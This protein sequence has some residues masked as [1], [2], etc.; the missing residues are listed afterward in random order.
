MAD[1]SSREDLIA[2][3]RVEA[4]NAGLPDS[5]VPVFLAQIQQESNWN[6]KAVSRAGARGLGQ[7]MPATARELGVTNPFDP[8][9]NLA[10]AASYFKK[11]IDRF[12][13]VGLALAA[14]N[15]G[16]G[17]VNKMINNPRSVRIPKETQDYVPKILKSAVGYGGRE[18]PS[19]ATL[20]FFPGSGEVIRNVV[21]KGVGSKVGETAIATA[22]EIGKAI[23]S[24]ASP[25]GTPLALATPDTTYQQPDIFASVD[26]AGQQG[27][28]RRADMIGTR[29]MRNVTSIDEFLKEQFGPMASVAD[30]FP[31]G[32]DSKLLRLIDQA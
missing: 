14:Y 16:P 32:Y 31:K 2:L 12:D 10:G 7:L 1:K 20:A 6:P 27:A 29:A 22:P 28:P 4:R 24:G 11:Q 13:D 9:Q 17:N 3:A 18:A 26:M 15:W 25:S 30:P 23:A 8:Q 19:N 5:L 21:D